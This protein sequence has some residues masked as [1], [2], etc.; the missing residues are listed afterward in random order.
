MSKAV[1]E[2]KRAS[3]NS[4]DYHVPGSSVNNITK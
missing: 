1:L 2:A 4:E 3:Y